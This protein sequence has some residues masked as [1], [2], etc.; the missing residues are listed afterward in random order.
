MATKKA[1]KRG[2]RGPYGPRKSKA[3]AA[4]AKA[5]PY[6]W[7][8]ERRAAAKARL[9]AKRA[10]TTN[11]PTNGAIAPVLVAEPGQQSVPEVL[12]QGFEG[13]ARVGKVMVRIG[14]GLEKGDLTVGELQTLAAS[15]NLRASIY[16]VAAE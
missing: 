10:A 1:A 3:E 12:V 7:S 15:L 8:D 4:P 6:L 9:A 5:N 14:Q 16:L 11:T 2:P 13:F